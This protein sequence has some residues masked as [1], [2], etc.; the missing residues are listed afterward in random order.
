M[1]WILYFFRQA[2]KE[3]RADTAKLHAKVADLQTRL[4]LLRQCVIQ[5]LPHLLGNEVLHTSPANFPPQHWEE[6]NDPLTSQI[7]RLIKN[8]Y[9]T[10]L[11]EEELSLHLQRISQIAVGDGGLGFVY[12]GSRAIPDFVLTMSHANKYASQGIRLNKEAQPIILHPSLTALF[13]FASNPE[14]TILE[15]F[16]RFL[17]P[18]ANIAA[19]STAPDK[20]HSL[21]FHLSPKSARS[22]LNRNMGKP[23]RAASGS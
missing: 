19:P 23:I 8:F 4:H 9:E 15:R 22:S 14:L 2:V 20:V 7:D 5:Q 16:Y 17:L 10:L 1:G 12:P 21:L 18:V 6:W 13:L 11:L 3:T